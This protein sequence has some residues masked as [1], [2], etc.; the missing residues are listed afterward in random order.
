MYESVSVLQWARYPRG[1]PQQSV[2]SLDQYLRTSLDQYYSQ[3][4]RADRGERDQ[5]S[6][7]QSTRQL[8]QP[9]ER[10]RVRAL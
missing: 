10:D 9:D 2:T 3:E 8:E 4:K 6:T 5:A 1:Y 7:D